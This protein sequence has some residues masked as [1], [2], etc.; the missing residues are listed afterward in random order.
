[1][2]SVHIHLVS[3]STGETVTMVARSCLAQFPV[4]EPIEHI[5]TT[6]RTEGQMNDTLER[7]A[8][9]PGMVIYTLVNKD[10]GQQLRKGC[11]MMDVPAIPVLDPIISTMS[12]HLQS[13][14]KAAPG[15]QHELNEAYFDRIEAMHYVLSHDDGQAT[16]SLDEA[17]III[18]GVSRTSKT[19]TCMYLANRGLKAANVPL[20]PGC[21]L[22]PEVTK[23]GG[24]LVVGLSTEPKKL[25]E[26]RRTRLRMLK[27]DEDTDYVNL[28]EVTREVMEAKKL[29]TR[30]GWPVINVARKSIEEIAATILQH[31]HRRM[32]E[33]EVTGI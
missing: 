12:A 14:F 20:V 31:Y 30:N 28:E 25:V 8:L 11:E 19:P 27:Q 6:V 29:F 3:D 1:M 17:D 16:A 7:I 32:E 22:P 21:S 18:L 26:I 33:L 5:W 2:K 23:K 9:N 13:D 15:R 24:P 10:L 4:V